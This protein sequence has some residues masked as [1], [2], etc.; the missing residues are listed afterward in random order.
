MPIQE[1]E[2]ALVIYALW[3]HFERV[4]DF[5]F[6]QEMY[7]KFV[8]KA[9]QFLTE[10]REEATGLPCPS[11][12]PWDEHRG[13]FTYTVA[14]VVAGLHAAAQICQILGHHT[15]SERFHT[16]AD[17]TRQ[18]LLFHLYDDE[19]QRFL[20]MI[21]RRDGK[22]IEKNLTVDAS[23]AVIWKLGVLPPGEPRVV[24]TMKQLE[25]QLTGHTQVG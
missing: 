5:E 17:E 4:Q 14:T 10:F 15:H 24:S 22:T 12:D 23:V 21:R 8:K 2:T 9:G 16:A 20:K 3:K 19:H 18:A 6:L 7:E 13:V 11:Y 25:E 1:D